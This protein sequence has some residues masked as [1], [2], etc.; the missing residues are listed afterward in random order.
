MNMNLKTCNI[1]ITR[2]FE[3]KI[4]N[5]DFEN[6]T[7]KCSITLS[8]KNFK[9]NGYER[10]YIGAVLTSQLEYEV[11]TSLKYKGY[12]TSEEWNAEK[13]RLEKYVE[14]V[15][16]TIVGEGRREEIDE[17]VGEQLEI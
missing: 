14:D 2:T 17:K 12:M 16:G 5:R 15:A 11:Y 8:I 13:R 6:E 10:M 1:D 7:I 4:Q 3:K 9:L